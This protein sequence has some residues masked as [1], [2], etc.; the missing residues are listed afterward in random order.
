MLADFVAK[1]G[2]W[3]WTVRPF[4]KDDRLDLAAPDALYATRTLRDTRS[5][6]GWWS[7]DQRR[8]PPQV[9]G[10]GSKN[11]FVLGASWSTQS[12]STELEYALQVRKTYLDLFALTSRRLEALGAG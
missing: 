9:L 2:C 4:A 3:R 1:V 8:E 7:S 5:P 10:D 11:K 6:S 12:E